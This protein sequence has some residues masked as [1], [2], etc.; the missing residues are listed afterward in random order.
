[1]PEGEETILFLLQYKTQSLK[2]T[3]LFT[4]DVELPSRSGL[5]NPITAEEV[6]VLL[7]KA[8]QTV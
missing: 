8:L 5:Y 6:R 2:Y 3:R 7:S 4:D 1:V